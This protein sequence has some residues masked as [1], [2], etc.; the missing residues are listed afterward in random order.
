MWLAGGALALGLASVAGYCAA[1]AGDI[2]SCSRGLSF[3]IMAM[4][5]YMA[6]FGYGY[7][8]AK[9]AS[10]YTQRVWLI[11]AAFWLAMMAWTFALVALGFPSPFAD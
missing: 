8:G 2:G 3:R 7:A 9:I 10:R 11:G 6:M 4:L 5:L 1:T